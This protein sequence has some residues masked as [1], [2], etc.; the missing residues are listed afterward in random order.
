MPIRLQVNRVTAMSVVK[1]AGR[2]LDVS[3][4]LPLIQNPGGGVSPM[5]GATHI[6]LLAL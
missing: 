4:G 3:F 5:S 6:C 2:H 1:D